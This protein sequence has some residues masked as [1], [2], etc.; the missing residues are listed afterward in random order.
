M[1]TDLPIVFDFRIDERVL[2]FT[3]AVSLA[4]T[5][6]FGLVP[7]IGATRP[8]LVPALK[9]ADADSRGKRRA[10]GRS[11][12]VSGQVG[13]SLVLLVVSAVLLQGFRAQLAQPGF[14][15]DG[16]FLTATNTEMVRYTREESE[17][18]YDKLLDKTRSTAGI[19]SAALAASVPL[20]GA[21]SVAIVPDGYQLPRGEVALNVFNNYVSEGYFATMDVPLL[22]GRDFRASDQDKSPLVAVVN[23]QLAKHY[24]GGQAVANGST[25]SPHPGRWSKSWVSRR[26]PSTSGSRSRRWT[27]CTCHF[28]NT[29]A[30]R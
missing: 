7:A 6:V 1:P 19:R 22:E 12:M 23:E 21:Y 30:E 25:S 5:L 20:I 4:S 11:I 16:L 15:T 28:A 9:A 3:L 10:W 27:T 2:L 8:D 18:Y 17:R 24:W 13:L 26:H 29:R 14:R